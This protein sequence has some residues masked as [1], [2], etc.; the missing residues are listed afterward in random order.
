MQKLKRLCPLSLKDTLFALGALACALCV[1]FLLRVWDPGESF[2]YMVFILAVFLISRFT[3]G[4][5][6]GTASAFVSVLCINFF[7]SAPYFVFNFTLSGYPL[8]MLCMLAV[9][10]VMGMLTSRVKQQEQIRLEMEHERMRGN[11]LRAISHDLRTPLTSILGASSA[12]LENA[13]KVPPAERAKLLCGIKEEAQWLVR[14]VENLL[15]V[16]R[17]DGYSPARLRKESEAVEEVV[18]DTLQKFR[19]RFPQ[20]D[21]TLQMPPELLMAPM[22][23]MLIEQVLINLLENAVLHASG[24]T[25]IILRVTHP[26]NAAVFEV[27][28][29]G[30]G[31]PNAR[32]S[33]LFRPTPRAEGQTDSHRNMGI[34]LSVCET[35][36][37]AHQGALTV[38]NREGGGAVFQFTLPLEESA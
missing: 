33:T 28:D 16:T 14:L 24:A 15:T 2:V 13:D 8:A 36:I 38:R 30:C 26:D 1:C 37:R 6:Y 32:L 35:I 9:A 31:I 18:A 3:N 11:L 27:I 17:M 4:Y 12:L 21:I 29:N 7:F 19:S 10:I 20:S 22:D 5:F 25:Q 34:G 23:A